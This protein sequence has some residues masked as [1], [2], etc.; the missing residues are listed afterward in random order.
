MAIISRDKL[1]RA[2]EERLGQCGFVKNGNGFHFPGGYDKEGIRKLHGPNRSERLTANTELLSRYGKEMVQHFADG[3]TLDPA[4]IDPELVEVRSGTPEAILFRF[5]TMLWS[6]PVSPGFGRR[7]RFLVRDRQNKKLI[8]LFAM[9]DP[10][11]NLSARDKVIGWTSQDRKE[12]LIHVM[13]SYV[14][15]AVPPYSM[16]IGGKLVAALMGS[17]EVKKVYERR[18]LPAESIIAKSQKRARLVLLTTTSALGRSSIYNRLK[19]PG[20]IS[21][22]RVGAT[23]GFGHFH[24]SGDIFE[25]MRKY[26]TQRH[27]PY[28]SG[29]QF[30]MG[31]NWRIRVARAAIED[32]GLD[33][34]LVLRH[35]VERE[36]YL[37]P[38]AV[39]WKEILSGEQKN[40]RT[41][42]RPVAEIAAYCKARWIIPRA[43]RD[44][45]FREFAASSLLPKIEAN[46]LYPGS[47]HRESIAQVI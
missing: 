23:K 29:H 37:V 42:T 19:V 27:H 18:Y 47:N 10:V 20:G 24:L 5:A 2:I 36:V 3:P 26:L 11:F 17:E 38:L 22:D 41:L 31:P 46:Q 33:G 14:V 32:A 9:G 1:R 40:I 13:D 28:A 45:S 6:V 4:A 7:L 25:L 15:G 12:R 8:G 16:L 21:F 44:A 30:G 34:D 39:N 43:E 35:G